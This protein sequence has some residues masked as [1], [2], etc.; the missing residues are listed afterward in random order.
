MSKGKRN[1]GV[2]SGSAGRRTG[3][4][5]FVERMVSK[6]DSMFSL[7]TALAKMLRDRGAPEEIIRKS[8]SFIPEL[9][10]YREIFF[11]LRDSGWVPAKKSSRVEFRVGD[12]VTVCEE[13]LSRYSF[14]PGL[15]EGTAKLVVA[16]FVSRGEGAK[17]EDV[18]VKDADTGAPYGLIPK[19]RLIGV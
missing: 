8:D 16:G 3:H 19:S 6:T 11:G 10:G 5:S 9:E 7:G 15:E 1:E 17:G 12:R 13:H 14:I 18:L 2:A 4:K